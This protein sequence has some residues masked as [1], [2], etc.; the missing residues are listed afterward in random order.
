MTTRKD[1]TETRSHGTRAIAAALLALLVSAC[2]GTS[3][4]ASDDD[5]SAEAITAGSGVNSDYCVRSPYDCQIKGSKPNLSSPPSAG[6]GQRVEKSSTSRNTMWSVSNH[7]TVPVLDGAGALKGHVAMP[8]MLLNYGQTRLFDG[9]QHV[10]ATSAGVGPG[11]VPLH[12]YDEKLLLAE[13]EGSVRAKGSSLAEMGCMKVRSTSKRPKLT[14]QAKDGN[15][16]YKVEKHLTTTTADGEPN[17][18]LPVTRGATTHMSLTFNVPGDDVGGVSVDTFSAGSI[19]HRLAVTNWDHPGVHYLTV[20][21]W[22]RGDN[23]DSYDQPSHLAP[24]KFYYGYVD[25]GSERRYGWMAEDGL[26]ESATCSGAA[27]A[28]PAERCCVKCADRNSKYHVDGAGSCETKGKA[29]CSESN[30]GGLSYVT[31]QDLSCPDP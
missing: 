5:S 18:Y 24:M 8:E 16:R 29:W 12:S 14:E 31:T 11:W 2:A 17:D 22:M 15:D 20:K 3:G 7:S 26:D 25:G 4:D 6:F 27:S 1:R 28:P 9:M 10:Y 30:R 21:L 19:F 23:S 13:R